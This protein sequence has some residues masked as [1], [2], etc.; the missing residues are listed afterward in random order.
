MTSELIAFVRKAADEQGLPYEVKETDSGLE[1]SLDLENK[2]YIEANSVPEAFRV[3]VILSEAKGAPA[4][5]LVESVFLLKEVEGGLA[6]GDE[7]EL[8]SS[9][10]YRESETVD[11]E[12]WKLHKASRWVASLVE[13]KGY[14]R[15]TDT[16]TKSRVGFIVAGCVA[17]LAILGL[18]F[19]GVASQMGE[20]SDL[21][22]QVIDS[23]DDERPSSEVVDS[24]FG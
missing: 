20:S 6:L 22:N 2:V 12:D 10:G 16:A 19:A 21:T 5:S 3:S 17:V 11:T 14:A 8:E 18:A 24:F 23:S 13:F 15:K 7:L 9:R 4:Y 1:L